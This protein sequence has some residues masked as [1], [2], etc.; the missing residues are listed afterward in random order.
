M[1]LILTAASLL[2]SSVA[3]AQA[4]P[5]TH[6]CVVWSVVQHYEKSSMKFKSANEIKTQE[7]GVTAEPHE[8]QKDLELRGTNGVIGTAKVWTGTL[9]NTPEGDLIQAHATFTIEGADG[10]ANLLMSTDARLAKSS[11]VLEAENSTEFLLIPV[12]LKCVRN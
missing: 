2:I 11:V 4:A 6:N 5:P 9:L 8:D 12:D 1:K 10:S 7:F 3:G